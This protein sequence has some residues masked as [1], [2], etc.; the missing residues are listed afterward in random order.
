MNVTEKTFDGVVAFAV[1]KQQK[2]A[3]ACG[4]VAEGEREDGRVHN[5]TAGN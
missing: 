3:V 5:S 4:A 1:V 2:L